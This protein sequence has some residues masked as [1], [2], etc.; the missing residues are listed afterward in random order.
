MLFKPCFR[1]AP[2][3]TTSSKSLRYQHHYTHHLIACKDHEIAMS[4]PIFF[5]LCLR[6]PAS[7]LS[8][9]WSLVFVQWHPRALGPW[10]LVSPSGN[11][12]R[13]WHF[14]L[15]QLCRAN[16]TSW[17]PGIVFFIR[18]IPVPMPWHLHHHYPLNSLA[19]F[20]S[21]FLVPFHGL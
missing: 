15:T 12:V 18:V 21:F 17:R 1:C 19:C 5:C 4:C 9:L 10:P 14:F 2:T 20:L 16:T 13:Q 6:K 11:S 8:G 3:D 7:S